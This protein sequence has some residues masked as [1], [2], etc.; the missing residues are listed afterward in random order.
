M[1]QQS[2]SAG[3]KKRELLNKKHRIMDQKSYSAGL[4]IGQQLVGMGIADLPS[5]DDF[6]KGI[7]DAVEG[8]A[9]KAKKAEAEGKAFLEA[10]AKKEGV[11]VLPSGL[12]YMVLK[13]GTGKNPGATSQVKCHYAGTLIDGTEFDSSYK[14]NAPATFG[15]NQ[16]IKGWTE[17]VQLMKEGAKYRFFIPYEL[18]YGAQGAGG[19]IPPYSA[20]IFDVELIEVL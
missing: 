6:L 10:N 18:G 4:N 20:L 3:E 17:G 11:I 12:Q 19:S 9:E 13:E 7:K 14:R 5:L 15:L 8:A 2:Y 16:V 1:D